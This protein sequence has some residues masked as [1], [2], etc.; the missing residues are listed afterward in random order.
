MATTLNVLGKFTKKPV[1]VKRYQADFS[2]WLDSGEEL[3]SCTFDVAV[4]AGSED[5]VTLQVE[6]SEILTGNQKA[7][8]F[9]TGGI[10]G[11]TYEVKI[12]VTTSASQTEQFSIF[13][14]VRN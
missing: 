4:S 1:A 14:V 7:A 9:V 3:Q 8:F 2:Q 5:P 10:V 13:Y 6:D 12:T 11:V